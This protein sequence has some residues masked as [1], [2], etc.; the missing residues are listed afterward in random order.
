LASKVLMM[1]RVFPI[2]VP[3]VLSSKY[4]KSPATNISGV[5]GVLQKDVSFHP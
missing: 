1:L 3:R 2:M 4:N 5:I